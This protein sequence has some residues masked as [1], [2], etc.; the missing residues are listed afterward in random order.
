MVDGGSVTITTGD[1]YTV[2]GVGT[3]WAP[4]AWAKV[5]PGYWFGVEDDSR[6]NDIN[7]HCYQIKDVNYDDQTLTLKVP[8]SDP[9]EFKAYEDAPKT[10]VS[11][12]ISQYL[13]VGHGAPAKLSTTLAADYK[14][15]VPGELG[16]PMWY[17]V[18][19]LNP[20]HINAGPQIDKLYE[21]LNGGAWQGFV[22]AAL[23]T[24][25]G[26]AAW[27]HEELFDY[28]D[29]FMQEALDI[30]GEGNYNRGWSDFCEDMWDTY[31]ANY[32]PVWTDTG[33]APTTYTLSISAVNGLVTKSPDKTS[34]SSGEVVSLTATPNTGYTFGNWTGDAAGTSN[35]VTV[36]MNANKYVTANF[37]ATGAS[38]TLTT[39]AVNGTITKSPDKTTYTSG[40]TVTLTATANTGYLFD[41]WTGNATGFANPTTIT[42]NDNKSVAANFVQAST[43][44]PT[45]TVYQN[46]DRKSVV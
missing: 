26:R 17:L 20:L 2:H 23:I 33:T 27:N 31:R 18:R 42:I 35:S 32:G 1:P 29:R 38:Y 25:S 8:Y 41:N 37:T 28:E 6:T 19:Q 10:E 7:G 11:Y 44:L 9:V 14:E 4:D 34:Y 22:L 3:T 36:T 5:L 13:V 40:E 46:P 45:D 30:W 12:K 21:T 43:T 39:T 16:L 24:P 15:F